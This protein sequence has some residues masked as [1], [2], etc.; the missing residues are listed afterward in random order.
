MD[1]NIIHHRSELEIL[2]PNDFSFDY[3]NVKN[4]FET[5]KKSLNVGYNFEYLLNNTHLYACYKNGEFFGGIYFFEDSELEKNV[6]EKFSIFENSKNLLFMNGFSTRKNLAE[7]I[8]IIETTTNFYGQ[9]IYA[10]T[11]KKPAICCL[12]KAG[13]K[14][15]TQQNQCEFRVY[16]FAQ[17]HKNIT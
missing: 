3:K 7:N 17:N 10:C 2:T 12:L 9:D 4:L 6:R 5:N 15:V 11:E 16:K 13:F 14:N 1:S 8:A